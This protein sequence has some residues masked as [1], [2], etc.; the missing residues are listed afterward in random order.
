MTNHN[1][2]G[3]TRNEE[4]ANAATHSLGIALGVVGLVL[5][6]IK[7]VELENYTFLV[8]G[9]IFCISMI[10]LYTSSTLYHVFKNP[11]KKR[12]MK[13]ADHACIYILIAGS[14]TPFTLVAMKGVWG[15]SI[16]GAVW[17]MAIIG[18]IFKFFYA[19]Q[20]RVVSTLIY[21]LMGWFIV[22]AGNE[23][24]EAISSESLIWTVIGGLSYTLGTGFYLA[25]K[26]PYH[27]AIWHSFVLFGSLSHLI[28]VYGYLLPL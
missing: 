15:W 21:L 6:V 3:Y 22:I 2:Q 27:H 10:L 23:F 13:I 20:F 11:K 12:I 7:G 28:A 4:F 5:M 25:K 9:V 14:Y 26:L 18:V 24:Y 1:A 8:S 19:G 17:G 16:F